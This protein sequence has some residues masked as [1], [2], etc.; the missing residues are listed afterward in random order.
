MDCMVST[1]CMYGKNAREKAEAK[2]ASELLPENIT[3]LYALASLQLLPEMH[4]LP[5]NAFINSLHCIFRTHRNLSASADQ[6][7]C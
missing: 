1:V 3:F 7:N 5:I 6:R 2:S 4:L